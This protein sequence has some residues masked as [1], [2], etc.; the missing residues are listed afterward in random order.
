METEFLVVVGVLVVVSVF[1]EDWAA[2]FVLE[3][4]VVA[5]VFDNR[6]QDSDYL[7]C[8]ADTVNLAIQ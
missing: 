7:F 2:H 4:R 6:R 5:P 8:L 3:A 1:V